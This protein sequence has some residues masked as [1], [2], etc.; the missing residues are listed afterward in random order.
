[1][2]WTFVFISSSAAYT[3]VVRHPGIGKAISKI[4][5]RPNE[6]MRVGIVSDLGSIVDLAH[7]EFEKGYEDPVQKFG[8]R[9]VLWLGFFLRL[10]YGVPLDHTLLVYETDDDLC[11]MVELSMQ[12]AGKLAAAMPPPQWIKRL[13]GDLHP[14][15]S[16]L[17]VSRTHRNRGIGRNLVRAC[18][19]VVQHHWCR[20]TLA[21]HFDAQ[22]PSLSRFYRRLG[23]Q[24][25]STK[26][27]APLPITTTTTTEIDG[28]SLCYAVKPLEAV[29]LRASKN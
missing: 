7:A 27:R 3:S 13:R 24:Y 16:N 20:D 19:A 9:L 23:F 18:E 8:L 26:M 4:S 11:G 22:D 12:P 1:M 14:Y 25:G 29:A 17:L 6:Q 15:L 10:T 2:L 5:T 28:F 21:L